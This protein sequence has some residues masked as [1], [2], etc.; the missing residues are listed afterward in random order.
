MKSTTL[1]TVCKTGMKASI[2]A[3]CVLANGAIT[4]AA[5]AKRMT[6]PTAIVRCRPV[7]GIVAI[8]GGKS[9]PSF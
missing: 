8:T 1:R 4:A 9:C 6:M 2:G 7:A 5:T 3:T